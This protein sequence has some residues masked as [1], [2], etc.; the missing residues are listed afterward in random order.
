LA[1]YKCGL[2]GESGVI[3]PAQGSRSDSQYPFL[4]FAFSL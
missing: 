1:E 3:Y 2:I 4:S